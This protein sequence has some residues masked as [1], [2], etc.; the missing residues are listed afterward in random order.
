MA[1]PSAAKKSVTDG[2]GQG[3]GRGDAS[4]DGEGRRLKAPSN[5]VA[6]GRFTAWTIP[7][8]QRAG[9]KPKPGDS[10]RAGQAYHIVIELELPKTLR[11]YSV[12]DLVGVVVGT[13]NYHLELP[14][15]TFYYLNGKLRPVRRGSRLP[16]VDNRVQVLVFVPGAERQVR[17]R[18]RLA[19]RRLAESQQIDLVFGS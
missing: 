1:A 2:A 17:D 9:E 6:E 7:I 19:S 12:N 10:P 16:I 14:R 18:I 11:R 5:A 8:K 4:G 15:Q 3:N 13:D